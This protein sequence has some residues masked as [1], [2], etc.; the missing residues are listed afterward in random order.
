MVRAGLVLSAAFWVSSGALAQDQY[1]PGQRVENAISAQVTQDGLNALETTVEALIPALIGDALSA[2][3]IDPISVLGIELSNITPII[4]VRNVSITTRNGK[5]NIDVRANLFLGDNNNPMTLGCFGND[6]VGYIGPV[7]TTI[8]VKLDIDVLTAQDG[9][10]SFDVSVET[11][12]DANFD[13]PGIFNEGDFHLGVCGGLIGFGISALQDIVIGSVVQPLIDDALGGLETTL[14]DAL[15][16]ATIEQEIPIL[17]TV[18]ALKLEPKFVTI[19][20]NGMELAFSMT[21]SAP[22]ASCVAGVDPE[23][24]LKTD[25]LI[26]LITA[27]PAG[28]QIAAH[29][30]DDAINQ[31]LYAAF[32]GGVLCYKVDDSAGLDLPI[33]IDSSLLALLGGDGYKEIFGATPKPLI[34]ETRPKVAPTAVFTGPEDVKLHVEQLGLNFMTE[35]DGRMAKALGMEVGADAGANLS[36]DGTTGGLG[37]DI[38]TANLPIT[39][40]VVPD[41]LVAGTEAAI[42]D[43]VSGLVSTLVP[44]LVDPLLSGL[45]FTLPAVSGIGLTSLDA[46]G[47]GALVDWLTASIQVG[48]VD[49]GDPSGGC[50]GTD[51][52]AG[53]A[54]ASGCGCDSSSCSS[55][56]GVGGVQ[57]AG[58]LAFF[59]VWWMRR[60]R[61]A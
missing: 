35:V 32:R 56:C 4:D 15:S 25:S 44:T 33:P 34:I 27:N 49:Y 54:A 37:I 52:G 8:A 22:Q 36:F 12:V 20:A 60:R 16:A 18:L 48:I 23:G 19:D 58:P 40:K 61:S 5:L 38:D 3:P 2:T 57:M 17:D 11:A 10:R 1:D 29:V 51:T 45:S 46:Y 14:E 21:S 7:D 31:V 24:S 42:E 6:E 9:T 59:G 26:P 39:I 55:G 28:T 43:G 41:L 47:S 53:G 50:G 30:A 13:A